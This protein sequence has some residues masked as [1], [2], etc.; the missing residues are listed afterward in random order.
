MVDEAD[1]ETHGCQV[2]M[3]RPGALSHN[4]KWRGHFW[5]RVERMFCRDRNHPCITMWSLG[6]ESH[7]YKNQD[8]CYQELKKRTTVP[9]HYEAVVR[10]PRWCY[11]VVSEMYPWH[12]RVHMV[13]EGKGA[14]PKYYKAPYFLCEYDHAMGMGAGDLEPYVQDFY[15]GD[16]MLGSATMRLTMQTARCITPTAAITVKTKTTVIFA[17]TVCSSQIELPMPGLIK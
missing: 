2:E 8:Y 11:D 16:N 10:T 6:N 14:L 5:D 13:A 1:I 12:N 17:P 9:V 7:G 15:R 3:H 4:P